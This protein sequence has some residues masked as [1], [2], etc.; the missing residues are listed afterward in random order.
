MKKIFT[1]FVALLCAGTMFA[2]NGALKG[3]FTINAEGDIIQFSQGNLQATYNGGS[4]SW[5]FAAH[6]YDYIGN[7]AANTAITGNGTVSTN[8]TV[9]L[10][11]WSTAATTFGI[12]NSTDYNIYSGDFVDWGVNAITNGGNKAD[13]WR[14][15]TKDEWVY[16]FYTREGAA[17]LFGLGSVNGV[18]G[19]I[20]LPDNWGLPTGASF[21][22]STEQG[23]EDSGSSYDNGNGNNFSHNTYTTG[24]WAVMESAGAVFLPAA[25]YRSGTNVSDVGSLGVYWSATTLAANFK[26]YLLF[27]SET[28]MPQVY[29]GPGSGISVRLVKDAKIPVVGDTIVVDD[30]QYKVTSVTSGAKKVSVPKQDYTG[31][32]LVIPAKVNYFGE[33]YAVTMVEQKAFQGNTSITSLDVAA[34]MINSFAFKECSNLANV[35]LREG[36]T[37]LYRDAF[38]GFAATSITLPASLAEIDEYGYYCPFPDNQLESIVVAAGNTHFVVGENGA[39]YNTDRTRI[40]AFPHNFSKPFKEIPS[41]VQIIHDDVFNDCTNIADT[42][43]I[44]ATLQ[45]AASFQNSNV[46]CVIL[47]SNSLNVRSCFQ[48]CSDLEEII[49]GENVTQI[50]Q[51]MFTGACNVKKITVLGETM[52]DWQYGTDTNWPVF[53][54]YG[55]FCGGISPFADAKVYV[56]CGLSGTYAADENKWANFT[57]V[58]DTLMYD[59]DV[60]AENATVVLSDTTDCNKVKI[61]V[62]PDEGYA[63]YNWD[64]EV[65]TASFYCEVTSDTTITANIKKILAVGDTIMAKTIED[66]PVMYIVTSVREG[67]KQVIVGNDLK[68]AID[69]ATTGA[70]TI[71]DSVAYFDEKFGVTQV[72]GKAFQACAGVTEINLPDG[73][74]TFGI[75][76]FDNCDGLTTFSVP[77]GVTTISPNC[78]SNCDNLETVNLTANVVNIDYNAFSGCAKLATLANRE[79]VRRYGAGA[80]ALTKLFNNLCSNNTVDFITYADE[81]QKVALNRSNS[82]TNNATELIVP[83]GVEAIAPQAFY[84]GKE[85]TSVSF[86]ASMQF[87]GKQAFIVCPKLEKCTIN[88]ITPPT[89]F[90]LQTVTLAIAASD[91]FTDVENFRVY[92]PKSAIA[93]YR[94][95]NNWNMLDIRPIGGWEIQFVDG[96]GNVTTQ[97]VE[98]GEMPDVPASATKTATDTKAYIFNGWDKTVVAATEDATYT[99]QFT[100]IDLITNV[101]L[102]VEFPECGAELESNGHAYTPD[103]LGLASICPP[104]APYEV[105]SIYF[106]DEGG[107]FFDEQILQP[108]R[109]YMMQFIVA[110]NAGYDFPRD[111]EYVNIHNITTTVNGANRVD[112][113]WSKEYCIFAVTFTTGDALITNIALT[114]EFPDTGDEIQSHGYGYTPETLGLTDLCP[115]DAFY[116]VDNIYFYNAAGGYFD[117]T[118]LLPG[119]TYIMQFYVAPNDHCSFKLREGSFYPDYDNMTFTVNGVEREYDVMHITWCIFSADFTTSGDAPTGIESVQDSDISVQ[120][121]VRDGRLFIIRGEKQYNAQGAQ[122]K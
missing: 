75:Y 70:V 111:G 35:T 86:P 28:L 46:K 118:A 1:F 110:A 12:H 69:V 117:E 36:V 57:N 4:W 61:T 100:E 96:D 113:A 101:A 99:A 109:T 95:D 26:Y 98:E 25:G 121:V 42:I 73:I 2:G 48:R 17:T 88:A 63:F 15:L 32:S 55:G 107:N 60:T 21:T 93:T 40:Y 120:K 105:K 66:V 116:H 119:T 47:E 89:C 85:L 38:E 11:G 115:K 43:I 58:I 64:N 65:T 14:T 6:Q 87:I 80:L 82:Y 18:N 91:V 77:A 122:V 90:N 16:L 27:N 49:I 50:G 83:D 45:R 102:T 20:L 7:A 8:G 94:A 33:D 56:R 24:Q 59:I 3:A 22:P 29:C 5:S 103:E 71:P 51:L 30:I 44:P 114:V 104:G 68:A 34:E 54:N 81:A 74:L 10:F 52:P 79:N 31:T 78:F 76:A 53:G 19:L 97:F 37:G 62:T 67:F 84:N 72:G 41:T 13:A 92:V 39:L 112:F 106:F 108:G 9:D 23:L